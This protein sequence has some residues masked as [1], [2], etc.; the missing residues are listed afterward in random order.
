[1]IMKPELGMP[2]IYHPHGDDHFGTGLLAATISR[3]WGDECVNL[4]IVD[5]SGLVQSR[6]SVLLWHGA[7]GEVPPTGGRW[8]QFPNWFLRLMSPPLPIGMVQFVQQ[9]APP[10]LRFDPFAPHAA[11][12]QVF[13]VLAVPAGSPDPVRFSGAQ[14][15]FCQAAPSVLKQFGEEAAAALSLTKANG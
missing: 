8:C 3:V 13:E 2:V 7:D 14:T 5:G 1:M 6:A 10:A 12:P 11:A 15:A 9:F 4:M